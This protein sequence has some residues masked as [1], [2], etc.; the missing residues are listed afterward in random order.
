MMFSFNRDQGTETLWWRARDALRIRVSISAIGSVIPIVYSELPAG[1]NQAW[2]MALA[3]M[4]S[5]AKPA[6]PKAA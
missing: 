1:L 3:R 6:H 2:D 5:E 4:I